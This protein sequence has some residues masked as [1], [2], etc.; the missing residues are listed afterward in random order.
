M[1]QQAAAS[2]S[3]SLRGGFG[4]LL[5]S[6]VYCTRALVCAL[7]VRGVGVLPEGGLPGS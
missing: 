6:P 2:P 7:S 1:L 5:F 3:S 4:I